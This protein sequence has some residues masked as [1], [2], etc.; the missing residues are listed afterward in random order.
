MREK[1]TDQ[2]FRKPKWLKVAIPA[3]KRYFDMKRKLGERGLFTICQSARCPN[4]AECWN[5]SHATLMILGNT[6]TRNCLFCSV[7]TGRPAPPDPREPDRVLDM[8]RIMNLKHIVIT[9]VTRDDLDDG[10]GAHFARVIRTLTSRLPDL[11]VEV[12]IPDFKG[13]KDPLERVL[14]EHPQVLNHNLETVRRLY[15]HVNRDADNYFRSL[16]VL[17]L[18]GERGLVT[19][20]GIMVG[21]GE[22][23][24]E[25]DK[26][27]ADLREAGV[28]L[29]TIGQYLQPTR[30]QVE[31]TRYYS[32]EEFR[33][34]KKRALSLGFTAVE[35]GPLVRSSYHAGDMLARHLR[36]KE[37]ESESP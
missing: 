8:C 17:R 3:G 5:N 15:P 13:K 32:P 21:L 30:D 37:T 11:A 24:S 36:A 20:S 18:A 4:I 35:S 9:S 29:L 31:V 23:M 2:T 27:F 14:N 1:T 16:E 26:L 25:L 12:L 34:L 33:S 6:C 28:S 22:T 19:K 10:G 7:S